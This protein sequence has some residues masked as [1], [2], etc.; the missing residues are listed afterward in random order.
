MEGERPASR[1]LN[2]APSGAALP[3][4]IVFSGLRE[5][6]LGAIMTACRQ[7]TLPPVLW[8]MLTPTN[9]AWSARALITE[10]AR[11]R[12]ALRSAFA[13]A[14]PTNTPGAP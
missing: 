14:T 6:E 8:A 13:A 11:E 1:E 2:V 12:E 5:D 10:L 3:S 9:A 4:A 7:L